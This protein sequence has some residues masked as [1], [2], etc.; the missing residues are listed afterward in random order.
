MHTVLEGTYVVPYTYLDVWH[1]VDAVK[2]CSI[3]GFLEYVH[4]TVTDRRD[5]TSTTKNTVLG[6]DSLFPHCTRS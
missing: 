6:N 5:G 1:G 3:S 2:T 4:L